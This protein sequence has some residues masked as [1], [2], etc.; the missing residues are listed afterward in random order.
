MLE[1]VPLSQPVIIEVAMNGGMP[2]TANPRVPHTPD[3]VAD[4]GLRCIEAGACIVHNHTRDQVMGGNGI[5]DPEPYQAAWSKIRE[6]YPHAIFYPT[7]PGG[8]PGQ[9]IEQ[10]YAHIEKLAQWGLLGIGLVDPGTTDIGSYARDRRPKPGNMIYQN[11]WADGVYM[12]ETCRRLNVGMSFSIFEP[13]FVRFLQGYADA[14]QLPQGAFIKFYFGGP[15]SGFGLQPTEK[16]LDAYLEMIEHYDLPWLV[17]VQGG[18]VIAS[19][20]AQ[21][22]LERGG[23]IQVGLE[24]SGDR[25]RDNVELV[26]EAVE[27]ARRMGREPA[28]SEEA[29][30]ILNLPTPL[31]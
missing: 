14:G 11:T 31:H 22:A 19:G 6:R 9:T 28:S 25:T 16:A 20:I 18:D 3:E 30:Q 15:R 27:L 2:K 23:H 26:Q 1:A 13:G 4:Q 29:R 10:R 17:S 24:P 8:A 5:H 21:M 7:M 12:V